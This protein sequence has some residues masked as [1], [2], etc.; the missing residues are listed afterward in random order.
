MFTHGNA[1]CVRQAKHNIPIKICDTFRP[2][3]QGTVITASSRDSGV[4]KAISVRHGIT[5][6]NLES[7]GMWQQ[8]GFLADAFRAF[9]TQS[10]SVDLV[11]TSESTVTAS[12]DP[13]TVTEVSISSNARS[14]TSTQRCIHIPRAYEYTQRCG[15]THGGCAKDDLRASIAL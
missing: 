15:C 10:I 6:V 2:H 3:L 8:A 11:A 1:R 13:E 5:I 12:I 7:L 4:V 14:Y 9:K